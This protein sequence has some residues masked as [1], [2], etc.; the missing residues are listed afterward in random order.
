[1]IKGRDRACLVESLKRGILVPSDG[2]AGR[3]FSEHP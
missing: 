3:G 2:E 1:M